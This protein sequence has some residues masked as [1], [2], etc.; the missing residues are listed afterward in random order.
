M[1]ELDFKCSQHTAPENVILQNVVPVVFEF[2]HFGLD[3]N[4]GD[5]VNRQRPRVIYVQKLQNGVAVEL[6]FQE[7]QHKV[8]PFTPLSEPGISGV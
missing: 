3:K 6:S 1:L 2:L 4:P 5:T 7:S 8:P